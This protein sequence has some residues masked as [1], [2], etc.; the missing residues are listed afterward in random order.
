MTNSAEQCRIERYSADV[1]GVRQ[2][3]D[4]SLRELLR[5]AHTIAVVGLSSSRMRVSYGVSQYMQSAVTASSRSIQTSGN[6]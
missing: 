6:R 4:Q 2:P 3:F 5:S 1:G